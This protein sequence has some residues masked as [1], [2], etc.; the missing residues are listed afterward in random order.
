MVSGSSSGSFG[1]K[2]AKWRGVV[3]FD[4]KSDKGDSQDH[5]IS[6]DQLLTRMLDLIDRSENIVS[7]WKYKVS[8]DIISETFFVG[9]P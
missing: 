8:T 9:H 6:H 2:G 4:P 3:Y 7:V 5:V 1:T